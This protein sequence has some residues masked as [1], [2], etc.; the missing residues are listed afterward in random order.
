VGSFGR[1]PLAACRDWLS[2]PWR[3]PRYILP[4]RRQDLKQGGVFS[5]AGGVFNS[6][7]ADRRRGVETEREA[8]ATGRLRNTSWPCGL[9]VRLKQ[10]AKPW[11]AKSISHWLLAE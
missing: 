1:P 10:G 3:N 5:K 4:R 2:Y 6:R 7:P 9:E 8:L 11:M